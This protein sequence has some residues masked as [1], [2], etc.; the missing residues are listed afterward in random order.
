MFDCKCK[1]LNRLDENIQKH[2]QNKKENKYNRKASRKNINK[3]NAG[4]PALDPTANKYLSGSGWRIMYFCCLCVLFFSK[5]FMYV[6]MYV[7]I[8]V[9]SIVNAKT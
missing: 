5:L 9:V 6:F 1:S 7:C 2:K 3:Q 8:C 4:Y